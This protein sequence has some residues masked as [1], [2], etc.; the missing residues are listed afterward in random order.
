ML[1][2]A[3]GAGRFVFPG[4]TP[5]GS[6]FRVAQDAAVGIVEGF[7]RGGGGTG[8]MERARVFEAAGG[9][10][11]VAPAMFFWGAG[12]WVV[13]WWWL[14]GEVGGIAGDKDKNDQ[15]TKLT[16]T[17]AL[18]LQLRLQG[19]WITVAEREGREELKLP[20]STSTNTT[21][22]T[23][24]TTKTTTQQC[25]I[26]DVC[27]RRMLG[28][29]GG[30]EADRLGRGW[31]GVIRGEAEWDGEGEGDTWDSFGEG[32]RC[33]EDG[34]GGTEGERCIC[35][36]GECQHGNGNGGGKTAGGGG[37]VGEPWLWGEVW[38]S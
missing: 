16:L 29:M 7:L 35:G 38:V 37:G 1:D 19:K 33:A 26:W 27:W 17:R 4:D 36:C 23:T 30:G 18:A 10:V 5:L 21:R 20:P 15:R 2:G 32:R 24:T 28:G 3:G 9:A 22:T 34:G 8:G 11:A 6:V 14:P 31:R 25:G 12:A 13:P